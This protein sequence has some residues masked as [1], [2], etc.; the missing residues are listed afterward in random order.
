M[1]T[2]PDP[3]APFTGDVLIHETGNLTVSFR[4]RRSG[5]T[6]AFLSVWLLIWTGGGLAAISNLKSASPGGRAFLVVWLCGWALAEVAVICIVAW[7]LRGRESLTV[8]QD[9]LEVRQGL[10]RF[11]LTRR[12]DAALVRDVV[13]AR[14][15][16]ADEKSRSDFCLRVSYGDDVVHIGQGMTQ[17]EAEY[18][19][20]AVLSRIGGRRDSWS[21]DDEPPPDADLT[22]AQ[23]ADGVATTHVYRP[24]EKE[25]GSGVRLLLAAARL[26][27]FAAVVGGPVAWVVWA[28][29]KGLGD[30][31]V[32]VVVSLLIWRAAY[33]SHYHR[34]C[35]EI[36]LSEDGRCELHA[37]RRVVHLGAGQI[38]SLRDGTGDEDAGYHY[39]ILFEG[40]K[41]K[42]HG[43]WPD[44]ED[45]VARV[46]AM[47][48]Y[49]D[50]TRM[51]TRAAHRRGEIT[52][53]QPAPGQRSRS[54]ELHEMLE[55]ARR[56]AG[57]GD[58]SWR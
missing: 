13:P 55:I 49:V 56:E 4:R 17:H 34:T 23:V 15:P 3:A 38:T 36:R 35:R 8:M 19:A 31:V 5:G 25:H 28:W 48:P 58:G 46:V 47:N 1:R 7:Q 52:W 26:V 18:L 10:A 39:L 14:A 44:F 42:L 57:H 21:G 24:G 33:R 43:D 50:L 37:E 12:Y 2:E 54:D 16:H 20:S 41:M 29:H 53:I 11:C 30:A 32:A 45:F 51:R 40:G 27:A 22:T 9:R 6:V